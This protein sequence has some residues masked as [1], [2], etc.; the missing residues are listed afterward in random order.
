MK[1]P[2]NRELED[3][4]LRKKE[5]L[6]KYVSNKMIENNL[7][8]YHL[9]KISGVG[10]SAVNRVIEKQEIKSS[11]LTKIIRALGGNMLFM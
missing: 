10:Y 1:I 5:E 7:T 4:N 9:G 3:Y 6:A 11:T 2:T 8:A